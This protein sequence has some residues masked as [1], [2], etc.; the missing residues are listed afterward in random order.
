[1]LP[2]LF[3]S[4]TLSSRSMELLF[5]VKVFQSPLDFYLYFLYPVDLI[6]NLGEALPTQEGELWIHLA[7][8]SVSSFACDF[9]KS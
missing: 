1:M 9:G 2:T 5:F 7:I 6:Q 4:L 8:S 3:L